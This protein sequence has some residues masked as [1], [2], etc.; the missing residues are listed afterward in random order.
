ME[1]LPSLSTD[2]TVARTVGDGG[3]RDPL[4]VLT[5]FDV[6]ALS[7]PVGVFRGTAADGI[8]RVNQHFL[9]ITGLL[10]NAPRGWDW[11]IAVHSEDRDRMRR[12]I[13]A[14][15][16][17]GAKSAFPIRMQVEVGVVETLRVT[18]GATP[19]VD[20]EWVFVGAVESESTA[21]SPPAEPD[22]PPVDVDASDPFEVLVSTMPVALAYAAPDGVIEYANDTWHVM[23]GIGEDA[24]IAD[25]LAVDPTAADDPVLAAISGDGE[26]SLV[27]FVGDRRVQIS[28]ATVA[29]RLGGGRVV[30]LSELPADAIEPDLEDS[31]EAADWVAAPIPN[32]DGA[33]WDES[34]TTLRTVVRAAPAAIFAVDA[35][36][37]I[38]LWNPGCEE[39][40]GWSADDVIGELPPFLSEDQLPSVTGAH[41]E[42]NGGRDI[43]GQATFRRRDGSRVVVALSAAPIMTPEGA[44]TSV[45]T[46]A[47]DVTERVDA[48]AELRR[49][50]QIERFTATLSRSLMDA[51]PTTIDERVVAVLGE[52]AQNFGATESAVFVRATDGPAY[53]WPVGRDDLRLDVDVLPSAGGFLVGGD[54]P[55]DPATGGWVVAGDAGPVG[56]VALRVA[57]PQ[58]LAVED[59]AHLDPIVGSMVAAIERVRAEHE[60]R[61]SELRFRRL[62]EHA[63]DWVVVVGAELERRYL[64]PAAARFLGLAEDADFDP[65]RSVI[66]DDDRDATVA[67]MEAVASE[68]MGAQTE[69]FVARFR[70][71]DGEYRWVELQVTNLLGDPMV[72]GLVINAHDVTDSYLAENRLR[73]SESRFRSLV[74]NLAEGVIVLAAD[75]SVKYSSPSAAR[76]MGF[77]EGHGRGA[78]GLEFVVEED[79]DRAASIV[80][81]A[82]AEP[83]IHGP[84]PATCPGCRRRDSNR[85]GNGPQP[86]RRPRTSRVSSSRLATS[87]RASKPK[88]P[89][90]G[91]MPACARSSR[92]S[93]TWS[94]SSVPMSRSST[95]A[96]PCWSSSA[97]SRGTRVGPTRRRAFTPTTGPGRS[98]PWLRTPKP[99][100]WTRSASGCKAA[101]AAGTT[102]KRSR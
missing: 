45:V 71:A 2:E 6:R 57:D 59:F 79:R 37:R 31:T 35:D 18:L 15:C 90:V 39:L 9:E 26:A 50:A 74:Q 63:N 21:P 17:T 3:S 93:R 68:P 29:P 16:Q 62:A 28:V 51:T 43:S 1:P 61:T 38:Q 84:D 41:R 42:L 5:E 24:R 32:D 34:E 94:R 87:P 30:T 54:E 76:M 78:M 88:R 60:V 64:S 77:E 97:T 81:A 83:G 48:T 102:W 66:H 91:A 40:F 100:T 27:G 67:R 20:G 11:L 8:L 73:E 92:T 7:D 80:G 58:D 99:E 86:A 23:T 19:S 85:R 12:A 46:V 72:D 75:G 101:T 96:R 53:S 33:V 13:D 89:P 4:D 69:P 95:R 70:R 52:L 25:A 65:A 10:P 98:R 49:R 44:V 56:V 55:S 47:V 14:A 36:G 22:R 82:F